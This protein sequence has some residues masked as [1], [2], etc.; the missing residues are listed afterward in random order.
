M[1]SQGRVGDLSVIIPT[2]NERDNLEPLMGEFS[3]L[4]NR[5]D[6]RFEILLVDDGSPDG[7][8]ESAT[9]VGAAHGLTVK[10]IR[11]PGRRGMG[12]AVVETIPLCAGDIVCVMD[13]DLSHPPSLIPRL[14]ATLDGVDGVVASRFIAGG[15]IGSW[16]YGRRVLSLGA[17]SL[18]RVLLRP[19]CRDPLSG[20]F[21]FRRSYLAGVQITG[22]GSKP[23]LEILVRGNP[24]VREVPYEFR[25]RV[26]GES[27]LTLGGSLEFLWLLVRLRFASSQRRP[28]PSYQPGPSA[29][30]RH[31]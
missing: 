11:R 13:G 10:V 8:A 12:R 5:W 25:D 23:L 2:Y 20:F 24:A 6:R 28:G 7:T 16:T 18:T 26:H 29:A 30:P 9:R 4:A 14:V 3:R 31:R 21:V 19:P 1:E 27:K 22:M 15:T 17:R